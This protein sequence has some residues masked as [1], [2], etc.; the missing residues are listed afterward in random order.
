MLAAVP[1]WGGAGVERKLVVVLDGLYLVVHLIMVL[2]SRYVNGDE[3]PVTVH[4]MSWWVPLQSSI[5]LIFILP[6]FNGLPLQLCDC[7][8]NTGY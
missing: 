1:L 5:R 3:V 4:S 6:T 7:A 8:A 2:A